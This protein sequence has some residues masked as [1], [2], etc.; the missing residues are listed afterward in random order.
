MIG[1][2][3][4]TW[5]VPFNLNNTFSSLP[6]PWRHAFATLARSRSSEAAL[7]RRSSFRNG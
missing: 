6:V 3:S 1:Q 4:G 2:A 5:R 7:P